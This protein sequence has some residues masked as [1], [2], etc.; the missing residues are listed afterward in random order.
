MHGSMPHNLEKAM[1]IVRKQ[2]I[3]VQLPL[4]NLELKMSFNFVSNY[5]EHHENNKISDQR[6][7][8]NGSLH[9]H[10]DMSAVK[11]RFIPAIHICH[12]WP[13]VWHSCILA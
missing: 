13:A 12:N 3:C 4:S 9:E 10:A 8:H 11:L 1:S 6:G 5:V 2:C 7:V